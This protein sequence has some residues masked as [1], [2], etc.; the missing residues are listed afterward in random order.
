MVVDLSTKVIT[1]LQKVAII[2][3]QEVTKANTQ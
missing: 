3:F 2:V 1:N